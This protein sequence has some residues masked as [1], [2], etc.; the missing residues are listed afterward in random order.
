[1]KKWTEKMTTKNRHKIH[2]KIKNNLIKNM[3]ITNLGYFFII[4]TLES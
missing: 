4:I 1:M 2:Q 3:I